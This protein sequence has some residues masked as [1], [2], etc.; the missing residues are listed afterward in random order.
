VDWYNDHLTNANCFQMGVL[1]FEPGISFIYEEDEVFIVAV[2]QPLL[3]IRPL[4]S[5]LGDQP[6]VQAATFQFYFLR[7]LCFFDMMDKLHIQPTFLNTTMN[8][9]IRDLDIL[10]IS[11]VFFSHIPP[12]IPPNN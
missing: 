7:P 3:D 10:L 4:Q 12:L 11:P 2:H 8:I 6:V 5:E 1:L 9:H